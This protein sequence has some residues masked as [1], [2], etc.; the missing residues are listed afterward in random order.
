MFGIRGKNCTFRVTRLGASNDLC[1]Q[2]VRVKIRRLH[3]RSRQNPSSQR[4]S[5]SPRR[6]IHGAIKHTAVVQLGKMYGELSYGHGDLISL[7]GEVELA[8]L[9]PR[10]Y[11]AQIRPIPT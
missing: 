6:V 2:T 7:L 11:Y 4:Q 8:H 10:M 5:P 9:S 3:G 1:D